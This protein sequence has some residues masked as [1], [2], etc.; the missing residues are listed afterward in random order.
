M[1]IDLKLQYQNNSGHQLVCGL[2]LPAAETTRWIDAVCSHRQPL[3]GI[4]L[5]Q[6]RAVQPTF[7]LNPSQSLMVA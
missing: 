5:V 2:L 7:N 4:R 1:E 6:L 3:S